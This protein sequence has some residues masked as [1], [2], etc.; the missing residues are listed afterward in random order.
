MFYKLYN[1][2]YADFL[3]EFRR[4]F[5]LTA[6]TQ[7]AKSETSDRRRRQRQQDRPQRQQQ[8]QQTP[9]LTRLP[10]AEFRRR[11]NASSRIVFPGELINDDEGATK[12]LFDLK[13]ST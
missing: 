12:W 7:V 4:I 3:A 5:E 9:I 2:I 1:R 13:D 8:Q 11:Q 10:V 6:T